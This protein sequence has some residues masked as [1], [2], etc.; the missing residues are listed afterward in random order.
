VETGTWLE[1]AELTDEE[2]AGAVA[3]VL[4]ALEE[5]V[6]PAA[7][8]GAAERATLAATGSDDGVRLHFPAFVVPCCPERVAAAT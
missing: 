5:V 2:A 1:G 8:D 4:P 3:L 6:R 7:A